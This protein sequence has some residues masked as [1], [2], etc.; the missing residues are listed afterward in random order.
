MKIFKLVWLLLM[1]L[2]MQYSLHSQE[3]REYNYLRKVCEITLSSGETS[4]LTMNDSPALPSC[5]SYDEITRKYKLYAKFHNNEFVNND[6]KFYISNSK[7]IIPC[8]IHNPSSERHTIN[9]KKSINNDDCIV[10][11]II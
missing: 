3:F 11:N 8:D 7:T 2:V 1:C 10:I 5:I 4:E 6:Y 9:W